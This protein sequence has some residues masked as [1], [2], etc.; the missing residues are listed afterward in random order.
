[1]FLN[2]IERQQTSKYNWNHLSSFIILLF[3][4]VKVYSDGFS[5]IVHK[6][7]SNCYYFI[8]SKLIIYFFFVFFF[9][10]YRVEV[11]RSAPHSQF[12]QGAESSSASSTPSTKPPLPPST[13]TDESS[14]PARLSSRRCA[15]SPTN[16]TRRWRSSSSWPP[17]CPVGWPRRT[18]GW[19][20]KRNASQNRT[21]DWPSW[22]RN[23]RPS[24]SQPRELFRVWLQRGKQMTDLEEGVVLE[25]HVQKRRRSSSWKRI[26][27]WRRRPVL[28][29][30]KD[31]FKDSA[32]YEPRF[33]CEQ[34]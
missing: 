16:R 1:M 19:R 23:W 27:S 33:A 7:Q 34:K 31:Y 18:W 29:E 20:S 2:K 9:K 24:Q 30:K 26:T 14:S 25:N 4:I 15:R 8:T 6:Y 22:N 10:P 12:P 5:T 28:K 21:R 17:S 3:Y 32:I 11:W 13:P